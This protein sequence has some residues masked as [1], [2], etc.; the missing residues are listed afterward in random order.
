MNTRKAGEDFYFLQRIFPLGNIRL[1]NTATVF[2]SPRPSDR[3]PFGTG[4]AIK[5]MLKNEATG[6]YQTYNPHTFID[7]KSFF[8]HAEGFLRNPDL[9][10]SFRKM[11]ES[12]Q[13]YLHAIEFDKNV[14]KLQKNFRTESTFSRAFYMWFN[15][16]KVLKFVHFARDRFYPNIKILDAANWLLTTYSEEPAKDR[17][18]AL[19]HLRKLDQLNQ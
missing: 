13:G 15:G 14:K 4:R 6:H 17:E 12:L 9:P 1:I 7:L 10:A 16:F 18:S 11:P 8:E 2:P 19:N 3:V 5:D